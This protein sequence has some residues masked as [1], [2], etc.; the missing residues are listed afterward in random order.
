M[1]VEGCLQGLSIRQSPRVERAVE[2]GY[3]HAYRFLSPFTGIHRD[4]YGSMAS[5]DHLIGLTVYL[6]PTG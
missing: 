6:D 5:H 2:A 1:D 3:P 4:V